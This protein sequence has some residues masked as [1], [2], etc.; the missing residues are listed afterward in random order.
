MVYNLLSPYFITLALRI[1]PISFIRNS[2]P[3]RNIKAGD[4]K[5]LNLSFRP[6]LGL[7]VMIVAYTYYREFGISKLNTLLEN[8]FAAECFYALTF[9]GPVICHEVYYAYRIRDILRRI[10]RS[11]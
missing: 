4:I 5:K 8:R 2:R 9:I 3:F 6:L 7:I 1:M 10:S 11:M